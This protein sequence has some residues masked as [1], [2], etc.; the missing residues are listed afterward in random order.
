[1]TNTKKLPV[2]ALLLYRGWDVL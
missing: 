1:M 2:A